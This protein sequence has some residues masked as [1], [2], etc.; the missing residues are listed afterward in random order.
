MQSLEAQFF[1]KIIVNH[2]R[3]NYKGVPYVIKH[4]S[5]KLPIEYADAVHE[6]LNVLARSFFGR[7]DIKLK[8]ENV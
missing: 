7:N 6:E 1:H 4:D 8:F 2:M 5:I 3:R